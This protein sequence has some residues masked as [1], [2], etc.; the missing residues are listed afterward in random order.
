MK[1]L[2]SR[3]LLW[4]WVIVWEA[5]E[6][7]RV[8]KGEAVKQSQGF[9]L[10]SATSDADPPHSLLKPPLRP[11]PLPSPPTP[12]SPQAIKEG[13]KRFLFLGQEIRLISSCGIF[14]TMNPG[15]AGRSE[16]PDNLKVGRGWALRGLL[17][18]AEGRR[19]NRGPTPPAAPDNSGSHG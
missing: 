4:W 9:W 15:Y 17:C 1:S 7:G 10:L 11:P 5:P 14:V 19:A 8:G 2:R 3:P 18:C 13:K 6:S 12:L 16:L